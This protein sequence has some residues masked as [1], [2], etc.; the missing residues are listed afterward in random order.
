MCWPTHSRPSPIPGMYET[1]PLE[2]ILMPDRTEMQTKFRLGF[3][4]KTNDDDPPKSALSSVACLPQSNLKLVETPKQRH[5]T[6]SMI[7]KLNSQAV[8]ETKA[9]SRT[10]KAH[11]QKTRGGSTELISD[12]RPVR[13]TRSNRTI[14]DLEPTYLEP[15]P[16]KYS[17][18]YGLGPPWPK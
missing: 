9:T 11:S 7:G 17:V 8:D 10:T 15:A 13:S 2:K 14:V 6:L 18:E 1:R 4:H 5:G 16:I 3:Q 12:N